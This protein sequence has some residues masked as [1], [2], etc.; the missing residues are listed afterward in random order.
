MIKKKTKLK[1]SGQTYPIMEKNIKNFYSKIEKVVKKVTMNAMLRIFLIVKISMSLEFSDR[2]VHHPKFFESEDPF[3]IM[4]ITQIGIKLK[5]MPIISKAAA[6]YY[7][8]LARDCQ[9]HNQNLSRETEKEEENSTV[10]FT[11]LN[12]TILTQSNHKNENTYIDSTLLKSKLI[13]LSSTQALINNFEEPKD[14][15]TY[16]LEL[17]HDKLQKV[18]QST[19]SDHHALR[20]LV[21]CSLLLGLNVCA[22]KMGHWLGPLLK[23]EQL[24]KFYIRKAEAIFDFFN[25]EKASQ[26]LRKL[27]GINLEEKL[28]NTQVDAEYGNFF[29]I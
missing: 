19:P 23:Q 27:C 17:A 12:T 24:L 8:S 7:I 26:Q 3:D 25:K 4:D 6:A 20:A 1:T 5:T 10:K 9:K 22:I 15:T 2:V 21:V 11:S 18:I 29:G 13:H 16:Y 14:E 28:T